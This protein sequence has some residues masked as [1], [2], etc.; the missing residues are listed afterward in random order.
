[1]KRKNVSTLWRRPHRGFTLIELLVVISI[2]ALLVAILMP[3]L[4]KAK[5]SAL[6]A[7]CLMNIKSLS[8]AWVIYA[9]ANEDQLVGGQVGHGSFPI[10]DHDWVHPAITTTNTA[11][12]AGMDSYD[13][14]AEGI[15]QGALYKYL[16]TP[17]VYNCPADKTWR[18]YAGKTVTQQQSPF[19]SYAISDAMNGGWIAGFQYKKTAQIK[20]AAERL[21][22]VEEEENNGSNWGSWILSA[23]SSFTWWNPISIWHG[24]ST[25]I[26]FADGH[27]EARQWM[28]ESTIRMGETQQLGAKP[29]AAEGEGEDLRFMLRA[30]HH[31]YR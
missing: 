17:D 19:R 31:E 3:A 9:T 7:T 2:I 23:P 5:Q 28:D 18:E 22:F 27:A 13:R 6:K 1:M 16:E 30:F 14:E 21:V 29:D 8:Q 24:R 15:K 12:R 25:N 10:K 4:N 11:Y 26:G 20:G